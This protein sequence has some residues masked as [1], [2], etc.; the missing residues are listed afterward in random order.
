MLK[1]CTNSKTDIICEKSYIQWKPITFVHV[2]LSISGC[3]YVYDTKL[4]LHT[5][6]VLPHA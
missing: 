3:F 4:G 2:P 5:H 6:N 1:N